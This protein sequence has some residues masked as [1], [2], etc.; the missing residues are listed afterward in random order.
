MTVLITKP[1]RNEQETKDNKELVKIGIDQHY[2]TDLADV[3][4]S[5][6]L[7]YKL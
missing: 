1:K 7:F 5:V 2:L 3:L 6:S 4:R